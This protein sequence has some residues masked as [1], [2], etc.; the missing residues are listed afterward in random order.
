LKDKILNLAGEIE[1]RRVDAESPEEARLAQELLRL[2][3]E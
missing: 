2:L 1:H 3:R